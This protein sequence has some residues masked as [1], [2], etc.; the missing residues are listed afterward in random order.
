MCAVFFFF[1]RCGV[2]SQEM[3]SRLIGWIEEKRRA[4][5]LNETHSDLHLRGGEVMR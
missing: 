4:L 3:K 5:W 2:Q 1:S